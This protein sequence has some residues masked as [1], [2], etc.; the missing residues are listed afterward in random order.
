MTESFSPLFIPSLKLKQLKGPGLVHEF[1]VQ[2]PCFVLA[3]ALVY[4]FPWGLLIWNVLDP[5]Y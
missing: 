5:M 2:S 1:A 4:Y 3:Q